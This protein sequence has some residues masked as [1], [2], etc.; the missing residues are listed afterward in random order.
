MEG[1]PLNEMHLHYISIISLLHVS[2]EYNSHYMIWLQE[3][4]IV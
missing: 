2:S 1:I 3:Y 4:Y